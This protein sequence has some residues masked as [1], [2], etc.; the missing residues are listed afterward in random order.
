MDQYL[1]AKIVSEVMMGNQYWRTVIF[2][3]SV[4]TAFKTLMI[5]SVLLRYKGHMYRG[6]NYFFYNSMDNTSSR[7]QKIVTTLLSGLS[8]KVSI[9]DGMEV[10]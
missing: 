7:L 2:R 10:P 9:S 5:L 8:S 3:P 1:T 4:G 6:I